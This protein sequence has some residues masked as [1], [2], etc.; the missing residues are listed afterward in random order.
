FTYTWERCNSAGTG[1]SAIAGASGTTAAYVTTAADGGDTLRVQV[2]ATNT[3]GVGYATS[4]AVAVIGT[5]NESAAG[6][7]SANS[8]A[9]LATGSDGAVWITDQ[10][11]TTKLVA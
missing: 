3:S 5:I 2:A 8:P 9:W 7:T 1:C 6:M 4:A 10:G 11:A